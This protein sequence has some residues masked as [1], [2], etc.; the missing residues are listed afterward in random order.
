MAIVSIIVPAY[1]DESWVSAALDSC[2]SQTLTDIE[3]ICVDDASTDATREIIAGYADRD[4][5]VDLIALTENSSAFQARRLGIAAARSPYVMFLDGDDELAPRAAELAAGL[6]LKEEAD[7]VGFGVEL[8][9]GTGSKAPSFERSLQ[10]V[11][12]P[13]AGAGILQALFPMGAPAQGHIWKYLFSTR[14]L[15]E[16]YADFSDEDVLYRANDIPIAFLAAASARRYVSTPEKLYRY[17]FR[18]GVSGRTVH[19]EEDFRFY[20]GAVDSIDLIAPMVRRIALSGGSGVS[21]A[22]DSARLSV[23]SN[24]ISYC[25]DKAPAESQPLY[26]RI[27]AERVGAEA[28]ACAA[29]VFKPAA[30]AQVNAA[31]EESAPLRGEVRHVLL[32]TGNLRVG[33]VQGVLVAQARYLLDAGYSVTVAL[34]SASPSAYELPL[35]VNIVRVQGGTRFNRVN[36]WLTICKELSV[37]VVIDHHILY[38]DYWHGN[39]VAARSIGIGSIGW[40]H[41]FALRP[42]LDFDDRNSRL[43]KSLPSL[44]RLVVLSAV[45]VAYWKLRGVE[46]VSYLPNPPSPLA[47]SLQTEVVARDAVDGPIRI[48]WF[49]RLQQSTKQVRSLITVA[50]LLRSRDVPFDMR[51]I[52]PDGGDLTVE[53]LRSEIA[54]AGL[55]DYVH[56]V[57]PMQGEELTSALRASD[58]F[59]ST[60]L[61]EGYP[62]SL[63]EA[64]LLGLPIVMFDLPWLS[65][66]HDNEGVVRVPQG[67]VSAM[68]TAL[69]RIA[70]DSAEYAALV[71][72]SV[73]AGRAALAYDFASLYSELLS[74]SLS[75]DHSPAPTSESASIL[76]D[77]NSF[78]MDLNIGKVRRSEAR[79]RRRLSGVRAH[80]A[81]LV[82][83]SEHDKRRL[84]AVENSL[85]FRLGRAVTA[86]P[87]R[88]RDLSMGPKS[89]ARRR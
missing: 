11:A 31:C 83:S 30:L 16:V 29:A 43:V 61:I 45:D 8:V 87:R 5:R 74:G 20:M 64:Q 4:S 18:R 50:S 62:L 69:E 52:G 78:Y 65:F 51:I 35:G 80:N 60:S 71:S 7:L 63:I 23:I 54:E 88:V 48:V 33:G 27:L 58:I 44:Q 70:Y 32:T 26:M 22:Y 34:F 42:V 39:V 37:D 59:V 2:L 15:R 9:T 53:E 75:A 68:A 84:G 79:A 47:L 19:T 81:K 86:I 57:G 38:N 76:L 89:E 85:S 72:N 17:A 21:D 28:L 56:A 77:W 1:N 10:P 49:G 82:R 14:L 36:S 13:L 73:L 25:V 66:L 55:A 46:N 12:G 41:N 67:D 24:V 40:L 6:A 3:V